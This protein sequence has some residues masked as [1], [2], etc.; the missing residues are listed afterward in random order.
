MCCQIYRHSKCLFIV[1]QSATYLLN[2]NLSNSLQF[3]LWGKNQNLLLRNTVIVISEKY[4]KLSVCSYMRFEAFTTVKMMM[5]LFWVLAPCRLVGKCHHFRE[6]YCLHLQTVCFSET[7]AS[8]NEST[9]C[10]NPE[11]H[12]HYLCI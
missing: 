12:H 8:T 9:P 6:I 10:Q 5:I 4:L 3:L 2:Q 11:E 1:V 7:L